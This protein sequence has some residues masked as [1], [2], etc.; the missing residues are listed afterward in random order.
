M[1]A[2]MTAPPVNRPLAYTLFALAPAPAAHPLYA[3]SPDYS[4]FPPG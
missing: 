3:T 2:P 1:T 4:R